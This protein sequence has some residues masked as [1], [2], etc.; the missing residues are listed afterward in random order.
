MTVVKKGLWA[1]TKKS[2]LCEAGLNQSE[3]SVETRRTYTRRK[4][5]HMRMTIIIG[6]GFEA[7][8]L[9]DR[10]LWNIVQRRCC[11]GKDN[12]IFPFGYE[13]AEKNRFVGD[14]QRFLLFRNSEGDSPVCFLK[15]RPR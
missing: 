8:W 15:K 12:K 5:L 9:R 1:V 11:E 6:R 4:R 2:D 14:N 3:H 7:A 10:R 13:L